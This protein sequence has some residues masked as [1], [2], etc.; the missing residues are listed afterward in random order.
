MTL[1]FS[2]ILDKNFKIVRRYFRY[3]SPQEME[4]ELAEVISVLNKK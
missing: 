3:L 2:V 4:K 1:P